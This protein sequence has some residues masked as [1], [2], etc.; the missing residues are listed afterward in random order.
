MNNSSEGLLM[1]AEREGLT[2]S[3]P[4]G[5]CGEATLAEVRTRGPRE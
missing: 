1:I 4:G 2:P 5:R 3:L